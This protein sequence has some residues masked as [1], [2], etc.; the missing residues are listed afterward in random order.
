[1]CARRD[2]ELSVGVPTRCAL[3]GH[4]VIRLK[5]RAARIR[6]LRRVLPQAHDDAVDV[7][8]VLTHADLGRIANRYPLVI[9][10]AGRA[11]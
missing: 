8:I 2:R 7:E 9:L 4:A 6:K 5:H 11:R 1:M 3:L 10:E